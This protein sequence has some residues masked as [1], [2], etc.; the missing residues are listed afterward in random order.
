ML[1]A[2]LAMLPPA[3]ARLV[4]FFGLP[5]PVLIVAAT[6]FVVP[7]V[8][9]DWK[10]RG[11]LHPVTLWGGLVLVLSLPIR[12]AILQTDAWLATSNWMVGLVR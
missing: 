10:T 11:R 2:T 7:M 1:M 4:I 8:A 12:F 6:L 5:P 9:W 3:I